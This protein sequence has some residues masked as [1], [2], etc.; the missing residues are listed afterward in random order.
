MGTRFDIRYGTEAADEIRQLKK[1]DQARILDAV[2]D[3]LAETPT[4][5]SGLRKELPGLAPNFEHV[6]PVRQLR[7]GDYRVFYDVD[8]GARVVTVRA[9]R[10]KGNKRTE[11]IV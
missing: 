11:D 7:V 5:S 3:H 6:P 1:Y 2:D 10:L 8:E 4:I 9:V